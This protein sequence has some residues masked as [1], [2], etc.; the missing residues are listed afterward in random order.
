MLSRYEVQ[1]VEVRDQA[2][3]EVMQK[4]ALAGFNRAGFFERAVFY[5][6]TRLRIFHSLPRFLKIW[7]FHCCKQMKPF[8]GADFQGSESGVHSFG[9]GC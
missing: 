3:R 1:T 4:I 8:P 6:D 2:L 7:I 5:G 9:F